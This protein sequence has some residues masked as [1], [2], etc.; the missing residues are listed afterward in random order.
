MVS[1]SLTSALVA[2]S[3]VMAVSAD[4]GTK[5]IKNPIT[6]PTVTLPAS[7]M[8]SVGCF[9]TGIP[10]ENHGPYNFQSPGNCQLVCLQLD[11]NVMG[12]SDGENCW[13]GDEIPAKAWQVK[14]ETCSTTCSGDDT[15]GC[16]GKDLLWV[17]LT[18]N[19]RNSVDYFQPSSS[20]SISSSIAPKTSS[21]Q[22]TSSE[23][24]TAT[25]TPS[26]APVQNDKP[27]T[28]AIAVGVVVGILALSAILF[29][30]WFLLRRKRQQQAEEDYRRNAANAN[31]F[32]GSGKLHTSNSSMNDS[33]LDPSFMDRRQS[34]GSIADNEDYS[35]RILKV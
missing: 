26:A 6:T 25:A 32:V 20:S 2:A 28:V 3:M 34:N 7:A 31:A 4:S 13:C 14:N 22:A 24:P 17:V 10:L 27:N 21:T 30:V 5:T 29:G 8:T 9:A 15:T 12:L 33:R 23:T 16:G 19:T 1:F 11:K 35:R 18:G